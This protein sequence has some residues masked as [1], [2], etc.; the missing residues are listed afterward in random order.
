VEKQPK[1]HIEKKGSGWRFVMRLNPKK[2]AF[3]GLEDP[4]KLTRQLQATTEQQALLDASDIAYKL[5]T[6]QKVAKGDRTTSFSAHEKLLAVEGFLFFHHEHDPR[7]YVQNKNSIGFVE[8]SYNRM[9]EDGF[10]KHIEDYY[11]VERYAKVASYTPLGAVLIEALRDNKRPQLCMS[12]VLPAYL[13]KE[14]AIPFSAKAIYDSSRYV[15]LFESHIG[16]KPFNLIDRSDVKNYTEHRM[17][18][19]SSNSVRRE[20][21]SLS[22]IWNYNKLNADLDIRNPFANHSLPNQ[23]KKNRATAQLGE[24]QRLYK[25]II[26]SDKASYV[27]HLCLI[28]LLTGCRLAEAW[29]LE[30]TDIN[31]ERLAFKI[32]H[33]ATRRIKNQISTRELPLTTSINK[34]IKKYF[35]SSKPS[36]AASASAALGKFYKSNKFEFGSHSLRHFMRDTLDQL[37]ARASEINGIC[38][39]SSGSMRDHYGNRDLTELLRLRLQAVENHISESLTA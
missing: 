15:Q 28:V 30:P 35:A 2:G 13:H 5:R 27:E 26:E 21:R 12:E 32:Q 17:H 24:V 10:I 11:R 3:Y 29:G 20:L 38:G 16:K 31:E 33:N 22:A 18:S 14:R 19:V 7:K 37:G 23:S 9:L 8:Q 39:W 34:A 1:T 25:L 36:S 6:L 4:I